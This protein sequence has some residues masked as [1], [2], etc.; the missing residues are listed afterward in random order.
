MG[1]LQ[2]HSTFVRNYE[3]FI[4]D[5]HFSEGDYNCDLNV[6]NATS[7]FD[8]ALWINELLTTA[9]SVSGFGES[10]IISYLEGRIDK[11][12]MII[13]LILAGDKE[14]KALRD[15]RRASKPPRQRKK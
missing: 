2:Q 3:K 8:E 14:V 15:I 1:K 6:F 11:D 9:Y 4:A 13:Q 5:E 12:K 7:S 10:L